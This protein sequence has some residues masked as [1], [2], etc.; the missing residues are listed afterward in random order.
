MTGDDYG[1]GVDADSEESLKLVH[2]GPFLSPCWLS[3]YCERRGYAFSGMDTE[4][5]VPTG[6]DGCSIDDF[7]VACGGDEDTDT[8]ATAA[9][10]G[11]ATTAATTAATPAA[12]PM[13][14][15]VL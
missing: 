15:Q 11:D 12:E 9:P 4:A 7:G 10:A 1:D 3:K 6:T 14:P 5:L 8:E 13:E 2:T